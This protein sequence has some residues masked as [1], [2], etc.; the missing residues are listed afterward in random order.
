MQPQDDVAQAFEEVRPRLV[1]IAVRVL[2][3]RSDAEDAVQ[4]AWLRLS[5][6]DAGTIENLPGWLTTVVGR[7]CV[8][9][10][11]ARRR[12]GEVSYA[13]ELADVVVTEDDGLEDAAGRAESVGLALLVVLG[14]LAPDERLAFVLH[15]VF[16]VPFAEI[17][18]M[19]DKSPA[20]AKMAASR[21]RHKVRG[22]PRPAGDLREQRD[23]VDAF[24]AA[25]R[26]GDFD[27]LLRLLDPDVTWQ[28]HTARKVVLRVGAAEVLAAARNGVQ[29][30]AVARRVLVNGE[31]GIL[32]FGAN[33][34]P[35]ALMVC[36]V[37]DG[38]VVALTTIVDPRRLAGIDLRP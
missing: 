25:A 20:A 23:V 18:P 5:R 7:I 8:D 34:R 33:G 38:R 19:I 4:E 13:D 12:R 24:L 15:D 22:A 26:D 30:G 37:A 9:V 32:A 21:A 31:P 2:G 29:R 10:L 3:S 16:A 17:G 11:R 36:T 35:A 27:A 1:A 14:S 6:Q 28:T